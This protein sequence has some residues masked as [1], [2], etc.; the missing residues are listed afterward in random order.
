MD[1]A[2]N[3]LHTH[4]NLKCQSQLS[5]L[6]SW[7]IWSWERI[8]VSTTRP[9][10]CQMTTKH[11][12]LV[13]HQRMQLPKLS[14]VK[15]QFSKIPFP[16]QHPAEAP[17]SNGPW[18]KDRVLGIRQGNFRTVF[19]KLTRSSQESLVYRSVSWNVRSVLSCRGPL[20]FSFQKRSMCS[21]PNLSQVWVSTSVK[22]F[23]S[24]DVLDSLQCVSNT[25]LYSPRWAAI[26]EASYG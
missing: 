25:P 26:I 1:T 9:L 20:W 13:Y 19:T 23:T 18:N 16:V 21:L 15:M 8:S 11:N 10:Q 12:N 2:R 22:D 24:L 17:R 6:Q 7:A 3:A 4:L 5:N 14:V